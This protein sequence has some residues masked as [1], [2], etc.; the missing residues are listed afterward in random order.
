MH[1]IL[2]SGI[3]LIV[4]GARLLFVEV[5]GPARF[6]SS[7]AQPAIWWVLLFVLILVGSY[8]LGLPEMPRSR[9]EAFARGLG[10][11]GIAF[12]AVSLIQLGLVETLIPRSSILLIVLVMPLWSVLVWNLATDLNLRSAQKDRVM[13][14]TDR[15]DDAAALRADLDG[16]QEAGAVLVDVMTVAAATSGSLSSPAVLARVSEVNPTVIVLDRSAQADD[17]IVMQVS[18]IHRSGVRVRTMALFYEGWLGKL[19]LAE[20]AQVS[21]LFDIGEVHRAGYARAKRVF[22]VGLGLAGIGVACLIIPAVLVGNRLG[23][24]GPL[25]FAQERVGKDGEPFTMY[26]FRTMTESSDNST[27]TSGVDVRVTSFGRMMRKLHIDELP[28]MFNIVRGQLSIVGP[29]P[30][31]VGYVAELRTKIPFYDDRHI[32]RPGLTGWAQVKLGY[33]ATDQDALEKLQYDFYYLRR[34]SIAFDLRIVGRTLREVIGG[35][36]R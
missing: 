23:N 20:L 6:G 31:Q 21:L 30:E 2:A 25:L 10:A 22:D 33:T 29:R 19:P 7:E 5:V 11:V 27:W 3:A 16:R 8:G 34:Q 32:V 24:R 18:Q 17:R 36:G 4:V 28:Q 15:P 35:L 13:L 14:I 12:G 26:K 9:A 1:A